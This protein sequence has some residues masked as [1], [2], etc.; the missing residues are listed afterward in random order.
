MGDTVWPSWAAKL[1]QLREQF[2]RLLR[3]D[4]SEICLVPNTTTGINLVAEGWPWQPGESVVVPEGEFP[5]NLF[6]WQ[7]QQVR[8]VELRIVPRRDGEVRV[9]DLIARVDASTR[10][11]G[12]SWVGYASGYRIDLERLV[13]EAHRRG[14]MVFLDAIQG[15]GVYP[16]DL[17]K[18]PV[19][20][21]AA[22][23]HKWLLGP[24]GLG[25]AMIA[26][27]HLERIRC[28]NVGWNS[29]RNSFNYASPQLD[30]RPT[31]ARFESGSANMLGAAA[32][33][34]SLE[35]FL[36][37]RQRHG[38]ASIQ[39][40]VVDLMD[41]LNEQ[42]RAAGALTRH[43]SS[44][45]NRSGILSFEVPGVEPAEVRRRALEQK[46]VVS[47]RDGGVRASVHAYNDEA[48][49]GRLVEVVA[50]CL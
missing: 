34:A 30:L 23:G 46:V 24:E 45:A 32:L 26:R 13:E 10:L 49:L 35:M 6:P 25:V 22:D 40:R 37:V 17:Q 38:E 2:S 12:V 43:V 4:P 11:I 36:K 8:G 47:C 44:A 3:A 19:D 41:R 14:V 27:R 50:D 21:L 1:E 7:N 48:D 16:L 15:L 20:F 28:G 9:E 29:V 39:D 5:S 31:A 18:T 42:L 33:S